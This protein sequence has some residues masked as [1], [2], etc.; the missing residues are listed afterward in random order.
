[1]CRYR[2]AHIHIRVYVH[3]AAFL[4]YSQVH[5]H[6]ARREQRTIGVPVKTRDV[7]RGERIVQRFVQSSRVV[8]VPSVPYADRRVL[9]PCCQQARIGRIPSANIHLHLV[10]YAYSV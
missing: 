6:A 7:G 10:L 3:V 8:R 4:P 5:V 2:G 1:M 9:G